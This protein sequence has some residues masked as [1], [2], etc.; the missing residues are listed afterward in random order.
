MN[1]G[2]L[3]ADSVDEASVAPAGTD[4]FSRGTRPLRPDIV[5]ISKSLDNI[6]LEGGASEI[7]RPSYIDYVELG[8]AAS[9]LYFASKQRKH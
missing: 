2:P 1:V 6:E 9:G 5:R 7:A 3:T 4:A 8:L